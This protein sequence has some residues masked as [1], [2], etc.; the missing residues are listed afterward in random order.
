M[1]FAATRFCWP[2]SA[3]DVEVTAMPTAATEVNPADTPTVPGVPPAAPENAIACKVCGE[4]HALEPLQ[5]GEVAC[6]VR[7]GSTLHRRTH[8]SLACTAAFALAALLLY[9]PANTFPI[10]HLELYGTGA[11]NT[12][13]HGAMLFYR[14]RQYVMAG[15][16]LLASIVIPAL[17]LLGLFF[18]VVTSAFDWHGGRMLRTWMYR[19]IELIGRWAMLDVFA[20]SIWVA[21]VKL[22]RLAQVTPGPGLF[23]FGCVVVLTLLAS[24]CFDPQTIWESEKG[25]A[26]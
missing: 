20:L 5:P 9:V 25:T 15:V 2:L 13:M 23:P 16:V 11:D 21:T 1:E 12:V 26:S 7:C 8:N 3:A 10:L 22:Q 6:C 18:L 24:A 14:D 17:K 4:V 19:G